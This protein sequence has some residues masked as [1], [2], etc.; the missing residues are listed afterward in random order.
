[1][2]VV[3]RE[4]LALGQIQNPRRLGAD[5]S[6]ITGVLNLRFINFADRLMASRGAISGPASADLRPNFRQPQHA[7]SPRRTAFVDFSFARSAGLAV[8]SRG[9][10]R[11]R[12]HC[13]ILVGQLT[14]GSAGIMYA[15]MPLRILYSCRFRERTLCKETFMAKHT[16]VL[17][18][19]DGHWAGG[20]AARDG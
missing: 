9:I 12:E 11:V 5:S 3:G 10:L 19:G 1:M 14:S 13:W 6:E 4:L 15:L 18:P 16:I 17:I 20:G 7:A 2:I 8:R